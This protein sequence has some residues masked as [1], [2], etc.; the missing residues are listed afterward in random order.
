MLEIINQKNMNFLFEIAKK[1]RNISELAKRGDI[2]LS[3]ASILISRLERENVVNKTK[4]DGERGREIIITLTEY[5][6]TQ[7]KLLKQIAKNYKE[8][9]ILT[10]EQAKALSLVSEHENTEFGYNPHIKTTEKGGEKC[11]TQ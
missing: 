1:P 10:F 8:N 7:V 9:K 4:S 2:T 3:V 6:E 5:G 11:K